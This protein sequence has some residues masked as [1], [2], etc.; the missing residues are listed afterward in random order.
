[1]NKYFLHECVL[2]VFLTI[3]TL[4]VYANTL[5]LQAK[6][7]LDVKTGKLIHPA[8]LLIEDGK[9]RAINPASV[10]NT[11]T[12]VT[13]SNLTLLPGLMDMHVHLPN[14]FDQQFKLQLVQDDDAL[15][16]MRGV[17]NAKTLLMSGFTTVRNLGLTTGESFVDVALSKA[18]EAGWIAAPHIIPSGHALSTTGGHMDPGMFGPFAPNVLAVGYRSG[19]ADGVDEVRKSVRYQIKYGAKVIKA[20]A[21]AG[22]LS[23][24]DS[25][26]DQQYD[27]D[28]LKAIV[29]EANRHHVF[30]A[31]HA[32]GTLGINA[33]IKAGVRSIEH[34][35]LLDD[36][37]IRLMKEHGTFLVPTTYAADAIQTN[38]L[39]PA[40]KK[41]ADF[42]MPLAKKNLQKAIQSG[43]KIAFGTD[44]PV[45]PHGQNAKEFAALVRRGMQP[46]QAIQTATINA[47]ELMNIPDRGQIRVGD[48]ADIIG[49]LD[50]PLTHIE[51]L[52]DVHFVMKDGEI[53]KG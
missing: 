43:V 21:T 38:L 10:P 36:E 8:N 45:I 19:V 52:E 34:G 4:N 25:V 23:E 42:I 14:D 35:S 41:K 53:Y 26:G 51:T 50:N 47:A 20:A 46:L 40:T 11:A 1:M 9:I 48:H 39:T 5:Y 2:I 31:V 6:Q 3:F 30:V 22:V 33:A 28:E 37:S 17:K 29:N 12:L 32:H 49:V 24:E 16:A 15:A 18:S 13:R 7:Y 44:S 27:D